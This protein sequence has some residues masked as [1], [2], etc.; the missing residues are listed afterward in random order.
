MVPGGGFSQ[1][2][3]SLPTIVL[4]TC[5]LA[6][7]APGMNKHLRKA[8]ANWVD[9]D[10]FFDREAEIEAL[11]E[12]VRDG[13]HT[14]LT[15][16]RRMGK[17]SLVRELFRRLDQEGD[18]ATVFVD[19]EGAN[20]AADAVAEIAIQA[21]SV[22]K[23]WDLI[24]SRFAN[25][26]RDIRD[27]IEEV[28][29][30]D[31]RVKLR[32]GID[33]GSWQ[34]RG[35]QVFEAL[36]ASE[37]PVVLAIDEL[38]ILVNR[39]LKGQDYRETAER[40][41]SADQF[42]SWLRRNGQ[43]HRDRVC[44]IVSGSVGLEPI[45]RQA[46]LSAH[47]NIYSPFELKP[48]SQEISVR[49]LSALARTYGMQISNKVKSA[50]CRRLRCCVPH[51]V[52]Q[53]FDHLHEHLRRNGRKRA[54]IEDVALVYERDLLGIRGQIDLEHYEGRLKMT[55]GIEAYRTALDLLT[56]AAVNEGV[57]THQAVRDF[58]D[59]VPS[60]HA[61]DAVSI[62][63]MLYSL[64]HDGYLERQDGGYR[65]VSGLLEEWWRARHG[66][67]FTPIGQR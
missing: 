48:W 67:Y 59:S 5:L 65:F 12:R 55:L 60:S 34:R 64:E 1:S 38:P 52:Q 26:L 40:R 28:G 31:L 44:L 6:C 10:R 29:V 13:T 61:E 4:P 37:K 9:G 11:M 22:Q 24:V 50:M 17:T 63:D 47:A 35:D 39:L 32:A 8:G 43:A 33:A 27:H 42:L 57:L 2:I 25:R 53:Y 30:V 14:L 7:Y 41:E 58:R 15:A 16:R 51:H 19:L 62:D 49:C 66:Q 20:D 23:A 36:A 21:K 46:G 3:V 18:F 45:L 54:T 56:E